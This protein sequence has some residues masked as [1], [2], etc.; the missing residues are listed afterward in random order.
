MSCTYFLRK[1]L[2]KVSF[3][4]V[5]SRKRWN[6]DCLMSVP[7]ILRTGSSV[8]VWFPSLFCRS[9]SRRLLLSAVVTFLLAFEDD[10]DSVVKSPSTS[11]ST[12]RILTCWRPGGLVCRSKFGCWSGCSNVHSFALGFFFLFTPMALAMVVLRLSL[13][14]SKILCFHFVAAGVSSFG[15]S[16]TSAASS[17]CACNHLRIPPFFLRFVGSS[18]CVAVSSVW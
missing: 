18:S 3:S 6:S 7:R 9:T 13:C 1:Q 2:I 17:F 15:C 8:I 4:Q 10:V 14:L 12:A 16:S 5:S 11:F